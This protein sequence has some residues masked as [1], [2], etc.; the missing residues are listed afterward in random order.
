MKITLE[1]LKHVIS[2]IVDPKGLRAM[3]IIKSFLYDRSVSFEVANAALSTIG[4]LRSTDREAFQ[5]VRQAV[6]D[7]KHGDFK[8]DGQI[9]AAL[10]R[11][12]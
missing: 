4:K 5:V 6:L 11:L 3:S 10:Q 9:K 1:E 7:S 2:E 8:V 12:Q